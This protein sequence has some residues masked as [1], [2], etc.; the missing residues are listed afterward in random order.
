M[1]LDGLMGII[2]KKIELT[3]IITVQTVQK[4][5]C[6]PTTIKSHNKINSNATSLYHLRYVN[7]LNIYLS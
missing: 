6:S 7:E 3:N 5:L 1:I 4:T 2:I